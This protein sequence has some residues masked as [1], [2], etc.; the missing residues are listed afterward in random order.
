MSHRMDISPTMARWNTEAWARWGENMTSEFTSYQ[1]PVKTSV[2]EPLLGTTP[3]L[4][5]SPHS[6]YLANLS[7]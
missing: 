6:L 7:F 4:H 3:R 1:E 5:L 2:L